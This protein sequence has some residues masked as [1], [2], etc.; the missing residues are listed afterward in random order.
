MIEEFAEKLFNEMNK[1]CAGHLTEPENI[2]VEKEKAF[3][4][5]VKK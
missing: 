5:W 1:V 2:D 3:A 4:K